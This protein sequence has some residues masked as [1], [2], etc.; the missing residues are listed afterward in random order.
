MIRPR[1]RDLPRTLLREYVLAMLLCVLTCTF[2][3]QVKM[4]PFPRIYPPVRLRRTGIGAHRAVLHEGDVHDSCH[5]LIDHPNVH[6][7]RLVIV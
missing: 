5:S 7:T 6:N 3:I 1:E 4:P 2:A